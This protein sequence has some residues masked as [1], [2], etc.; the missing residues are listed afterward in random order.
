MESPKKQ[1]AQGRLQPPAKIE[2]VDRLSCGSQLGF[3]QTLTAWLASRRS[4]GVMG[5]SRRLLTLAPCRSLLTS[6]PEALK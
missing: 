4:Q 6:L 2:G 3:F 1:R 5:R